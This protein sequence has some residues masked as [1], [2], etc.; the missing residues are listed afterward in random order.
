MLIDLTCP[1]EV[2]E[3]VLPTEE[4]PAVSLALFNLSDRVIVSVEVTLKLLGGSGAEKDRVTYRARA[5]NGRPHS[6]F[7]MNVPCN[8][9]PAA[10]RAEVTVDKVWF[11]DNDVWRRELSASVE[12]TPNDLPV[13]KALTNLRYIAGENA[14][15]YPT[16]QN[17]LWV[18]VC[19]RPNPEKDLYCARCRRQRDTVFTC[20]NRESVEKQIAQREK[21]LE[22]STRSVRED[23]ARMQRI[24]EEEYNLKQQRKASRKRTALCLPLFLAL[25]AAIYFAGYPAL[26][27][28]S[29]AGAMN[30]GEYGAAIPALRDLGAFPGAE[31]RLRECEWQEAKALYASAETGEELKA[32]SAALRA[33]A[34]QEE[35]ISLAEEAD[36]RRAALAIE[37]R[38]PDGAREALE[39]LAEDDERKKAIE[40]DCLLLEAKVLMAREQYAAA[41][42]TFLAV[43]DVF[44]EAQ[45]LAAECVYIPASAMIDEGRYDEAISELNRIPDH[46]M[47]RQAILECHY[48]KAAAAAEAGDLETAAAEYLLAD[49]YGDAKEKTNETVFAIAEN[50][51]AAGDVQGAQT[52]FASLPG[53]APA[54]Q[55]NG[56]CLLELA[57]AAASA[58]D[59]TRAMEL[60]NAMPEI[61]EAAAK[62][63]PQTAY[64]A[65]AAALK[66]KEYEKAAGYFEQAGDYRDAPT[67]LES[68]LE[69]LTR[70]KLDALDGAGALALIPRITHSKYYE[71]YKKEAEYLD[72]AA[73]MDAGGDPAEFL[74]VFEAFGNYMEA[75]TRV[76]QLHYALAARAAE[77]GETLAAARAYEQAGD[78]EDAEAKAAELYDAY[79]GECAASAKEYAA[80]GDWAMAVTLLD[81]VDRSSL[82]AA[83]ADLK[84][85]YEDAC[86]KA[87][88]ALYQAGRP[89]EA[90]R[91]FRLANNPRRTSRWLEN[92]CYKIIGTWTDKND[93]P[94]AVFRED[95]TCDIAGERF[96]FLVSDTFTLKTETDGE[97]KA[98][99]RISDLT[100]THLSLRDTREGH[101]KQYSLTR[102]TGPAESDDGDADGSAVD[103]SEFAINAEN[104]GGSAVDSSDDS[105]KAEDGEAAL[106]RDGE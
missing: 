40:N 48:H 100:Q 72:A 64:Q 10:R 75:K 28:W 15:G 39:L 101:E 71:S 98:T 4:I 55:R 5:L 49:S 34:G 37:A 99:F 63:I 70:E 25:F 52:L 7:P 14:V 54:V 53:Y 50:T 78:W 35:S 18:C 87:G 17:G 1:A 24:R 94:I 90:A 56:E 79:Y 44:P 30:R 33:V 9:C 69:S 8:P 104:G 74:P 102:W 46:P 97:M 21:Q 81:T 105:A 41:R 83:Y 36:L 47:S 42:E 82:P 80:A 57:K 95:S 76:K 68:A 92:A 51:Y 45:T 26:R 66:K 106:V 13:S 91:Y 2:F 11:S 59:Y 20:F 85:L 23:T 86:V 73:K 32:A 96:V 31:S 3:A 65:G 88:E 29:A 12:Y 60:L 89:Y 22:L 62:M 43:A 103:S 38:D 84:Q 61:T 6:T 77:R 16:I 67:K 58:R 27:L 93:T 19:G